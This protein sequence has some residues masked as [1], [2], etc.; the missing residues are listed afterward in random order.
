MVLPRKLESQRLSERAQQ[1]QVWQSRQK[2][3]T[4]VIYRNSTSLNLN[5]PCPSPGS[6][7]LLYCPNGATIYKATQVQKAKNPLPSYPYNQSLSKPCLFSVLHISCPHLLDFIPTITVLI[8]VLMIPCQ[9]QCNSPLISLAV[10]PTAAACSMALLSRWGSSSTSGIILDP[11]LLLQ[12]HSTLCFSQRN[13]LPLEEE[14]ATHSCFLAWESPW[15][16]EP[17]RL[18]SMG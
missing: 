6:S 10:L 16:E 18:Q 2:N 11:F 9:A 4:N 7:C 8:Q 14:R 17:G 13:L 15:T 1:P 3:W 5:S 12:L